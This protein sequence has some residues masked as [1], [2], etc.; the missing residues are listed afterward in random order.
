M[1]DYLSKPI[2]R[3]ELMRCLSRWIANAGAHAE[4]SISQPDQQKDLR[5]PG[6]DVGEALERLG[7]SAPV[8]YR[9]LRQF[10]KDQRKTVKDLERAIQT[11]DPPKVKLLAHSIA[12]AGGNIGAA[13]LRRIA[14]KLEQDAEQG[15]MEKFE[16]LFAQLTEAFNEV[17]GSIDTMDLNGDAGVVDRGEQLRPAL[18]KAQLPR[19]LEKL[20]TSLQEMDPVGADEVI[21]AL[22]AWEAQE[23]LETAKTELIDRVSDLEYDQALETL[24]RIKTILENEKRETRK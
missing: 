16:A 21:A 19:L 1:N 8:F 15:V 11:E 10:A 7:I 22:A 2:N 9:I 17:T 24:Q 6:I 23:S 14:I 20:E 5:F 12:G 13:K 3:K 18:D 4:V